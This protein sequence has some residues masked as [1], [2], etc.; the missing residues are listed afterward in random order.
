MSGVPG[1]Q[2]RPDGNKTL[3]SK[4][5]LVGIWLTFLGV[6]INA[7]ISYLNIQASNEIKTQQA[8]F[9]QQQSQQSLAIDRIKTDLSRKNQDLSRLQFVK[10][11]LPDAVS[12]EKKSAT[13]LTLV[14]LTLTEGEYKQ[15]V[16]ALSTS[17]DEELRKLGETGLTEIE[18]RDQKEYNQLAALVAKI[19]SDTKSI[20]LKAMDDLYGYINNPKMISAVLTSLSDARDNPEHVNGRV[21]AL[22]LL[23]NAGDSAWTAQNLQQADEVMDGLRVGAESVGPPFGPQTA[24]VYKSVITRLNSLRNAN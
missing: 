5:K 13:F 9:D 23:R 1:E 6:A 12:P 3:E 8:L 17:T 15:L 18:A 10:E 20:R 21:N 4:V 24:R 19:H 22:Y 14:Q 11:L 16:S 7:F 2:P